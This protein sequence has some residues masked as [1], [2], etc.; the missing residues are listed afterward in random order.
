MIL[1][2]LSIPPNSLKNIFSINLAG[3][4]LNRVPNPK[5]VD[6]CKYVNI[7]KIINNKVKIINKNLIL[8]KKGKL[9]NRAIK[10]FL[11]LVSIAR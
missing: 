11:E 10:V 7:K 9:E 5:I 1:G 4:N 2:K 6:G 8:N 3:I